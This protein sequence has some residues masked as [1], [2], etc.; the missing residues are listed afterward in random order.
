[1]KAIVTL[2]R[3]AELA[4]LLP[5]KILS[6]KF[7]T[8]YL[9]PQ[10][11]FDRFTFGQDRHRTTAQIWERLVVVDVEMSCAVLGNN[12]NVIGFPTRAF[13]LQVNCR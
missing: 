11:F 9:R 4:K 8:D 12:D 7:S 6:R 2:Q 10:R 3:P 5:T 13:G 1:M